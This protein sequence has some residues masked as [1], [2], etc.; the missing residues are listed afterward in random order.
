MICVSHSILMGGGLPRTWLSC[1]RVYAPHMTNY[2]RILFPLTELF[3]NR[4]FI[5]YNRCPNL[6]F[7]FLLMST[8]SGSDHGVV[9]LMGDRHSTLKAYRI[10]LR[11]LFQTGLSI[12]LFWTDFLVYIG[13]E[14]F[15]NAVALVGSNFVQTVSQDDLHPGG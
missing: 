1:P 9:T 14:R 7:P 4:D 3:I 12:Y 6:F 15:P 13:N 10:C 5:Y 2:V 11:L 8:S